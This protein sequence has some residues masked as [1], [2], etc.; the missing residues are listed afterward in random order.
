MAYETTHLSAVEF[1]FDRVPSILAGLAV[2]LVLIALS[3]GVDIGHPEQDWDGNSARNQH[4][5]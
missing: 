1:S 2:G 5:R 3:Q 4:F